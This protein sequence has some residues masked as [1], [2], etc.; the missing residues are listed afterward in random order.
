MGNVQCAKI[1]LSANILLQNLPLHVTGDR[2]LVVVGSGKC[3]TTVE[4]L[5]PISLEDVLDF[6]AAKI[7]IK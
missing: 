3:A 1:L 5:V 7:G 6:I 2:S 4:C